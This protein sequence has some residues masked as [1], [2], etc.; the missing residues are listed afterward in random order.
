MMA[1]VVLGAALLLVA[2]VGT[3]GEVTLQDQLGWLS[4]GALAFVP[5][6]I[7]NARWIVR[8]R[9][10]VLG[11]RH[12]AAAAPGSTLGRPPGQGADPALGTERFVAGGR[13]TRYHRTHC[14]LVQG[15]PVSAH[16]RSEQE[17]A[18]REACGVCR[19]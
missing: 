5:V 1:G 4:V 12:R 11:Q 10:S 9:R 18:G 19:P 17:Q 8:G 6:A 15:K 14:Q 13:M 7:V 3:S 2:W 16:S